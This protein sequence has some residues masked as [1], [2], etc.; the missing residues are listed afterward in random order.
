MGIPRKLVMLAV[1]LF[2][3]GETVSI[4]SWIGA[5]IARGAGL[6]QTP[7]SPGNCCTNHVC[8]P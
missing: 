4:S 2:I 5:T 1:I 3:L 7:L 8:C 6:F